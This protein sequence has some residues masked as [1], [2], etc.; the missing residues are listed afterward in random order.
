MAID[1]PETIDAASAC[2]PKRSGGCQAG[3]FLASRGMA[4]QPPGE[5]SRT[6]ALRL[7][8]RGV[9]GLRPD[10]AINETEWCALPGTEKSMENPAIIIGPTADPA[11]RKSFALLE[12]LAPGSRNSTPVYPDRRFCRA[13]IGTPAP[14]RTT[15]R[16]HPSGHDAHRAWLLLRSKRE[17]PH[18]TDR[19]AAAGYDSAGLPGPAETAV[20]DAASRVH[21]VAP[22]TIAP[23]TAKTSRTRSDEVVSPERP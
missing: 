6:T 4:A 3:D 11:A 2:G 16:T 12:P 7:V 1:R 14:N 5:E 9:A 23:I 19:I 21:A 13:S 17:W 20:G 8:D 18:Q 10:Q 22:V 15:S